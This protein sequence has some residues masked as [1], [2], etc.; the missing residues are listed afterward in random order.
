MLRI[1]ILLAA[2]AAGG[3]AA[4]MALAVRGQ[5]AAVTVAKPP[6]PAQCRMCWSRLPIS[7][8]VRRSPRRPCAGNPGRRARLIPPTLLG[9]RGPMRCRLWRA[10]SCATACLPTNPFE[11]RIWFL[12]TPVFSRQGC[13]QASALRRCRFRH[14]ALPAVSFCRTTGW[15]LSLRSQKKKAS[16]S[17]ERSLETFWCWPS[18]KSSTSRTRTS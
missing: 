4:W 17:A 3:V 1:A 11:T 13:R 16:L 8:S 9:R 5:P 2:L 6:P 10:G 15:T 18:T 14:K 12:L 7:D